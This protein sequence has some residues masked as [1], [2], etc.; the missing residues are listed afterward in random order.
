MGRLGSGS[1]ASGV[2][3]TKNLTKLTS[4]YTLKKQS[5]TGTLPKSIRAIDEGQ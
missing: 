1:S 3:L 5:K 4:C 2:N